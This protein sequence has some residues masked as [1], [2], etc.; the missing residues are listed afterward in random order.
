MTLA[1]F[2][3]GANVRLANLASVACLLKSFN[4]KLIIYK[5]AYFG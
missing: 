1:Y 2:T 4:A 5:T 3:L